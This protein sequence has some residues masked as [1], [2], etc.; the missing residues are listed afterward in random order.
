MVRL[1]PALL[2]ALDR[3]IAEDHPGISRPEAIRVAFRDWA[4]ARGLLPKEEER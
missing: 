1:Q 3:F 4:I 2:T